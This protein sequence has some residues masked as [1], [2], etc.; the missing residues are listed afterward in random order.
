MF[1]IQQAKL[2]T[3]ILRQ[4]ALRSEWRT[5]LSE[6][7]IYPC[8]QVC[9]RSTSTP[10]AKAT[11]EKSKIKKLMVANRGE[12]AVRV[13]R[14]ATEAGIRTVA[15]YSEQDAKNIH[16]QKADEAYL[17]SKGMPPVAAYL[18]IPE[19]IRTAKVRTYCT[20][21]LFCFLPELL[22]NGFSGF[23]SSL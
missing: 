1:R 18:N 14:A 17:I 4:F 13:F 5:A 12:I 7:Y 23:T 19:L 20:I 8:I 6:K 2:R 9:C 3:N 11:P 21:T 22:A 16:R 15:V 10:Q